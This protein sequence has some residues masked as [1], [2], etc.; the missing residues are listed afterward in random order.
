ME[1]ILNSAAVD[2]ILAGRN[3]PSR[4]GYTGLPDT[5][6]EVSARE[7][8][9]LFKKCREETER[10]V[11]R[12]WR[13]GK[14]EPMLTAGLCRT[15]GVDGVG[16]FL[17]Y[18]VYRRLREDG[19]TWDVRSWAGAFRTPV[20]DG[21]IDRYGVAAIPAE[22][23][24]EMVMQ[25]RRYV[26]A[27]RLHG[28]EA[29]RE[30]S[31]MDPYEDEVL[32]LRPEKLD[33]VSDNGDAQFFYARSGYGCGPGNDNSRIFGVR[34]SDGMETNH[35][36]KDFI[37]I[38]N[39]EGMPAWVKERAEEMHA[40]YEKL[41]EREKQALRASKSP[42]SGE[43]SWDDL[44]EDPEEKEEKS[45]PCPEESFAVES[46]VY[47]EKP[48]DGPGRTGTPSAGQAMYAV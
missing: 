41:T 21:N 12:G 5:G 6:A 30:K 24:N 1:A 27:L 25:F 38:A 42:L 18:N 26:I 23:L 11:S 39:G 20:S 48:D 10:M 22:A 17:S 37:G 46:R 19:L 31:Y 13:N 3:R 7:K 16:T 2:R 29:V 45:G 9:A 15:Y 44:G 40:A 43:I 35:Q 14:M 34:L 4:Y 8:S 33:P 36:R 32:V 28:Q 47:A